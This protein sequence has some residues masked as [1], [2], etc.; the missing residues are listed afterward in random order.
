VMNTLAPKIGDEYVLTRHNR[1]DGTGKQREI[2]EVRG[3]TYE[4]TTY[5]SEIEG[6]RIAEVRAA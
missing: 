5:D 1:G 4:L 6:T 3:E 2:I